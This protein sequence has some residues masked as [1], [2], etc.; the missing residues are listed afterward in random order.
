MKLQKP[1]IIFKNFFFFNEKETKVLIK[2]IFALILIFIVIN[3]GGIFYNELFFHNILK[4]ILLEL[5]FIIILLNPVNGIYLVLLAVPLEFTE[6]WFHY[7]VIKLYRIIIL[8]MF[9]SWGIRK[10]IYKDFKFLNYFKN[11]IIIFLI[12]FIFWNIVT[13]FYS[14]LWKAGFGEIIRMSF[15]LLFIIMLLDLIKKFKEIK[16]FIYYL[17]Y[18]SI[19]IALIGLY[20]KFTKTIIYYPKSPGRIGATFFDP[21][22]FGRYLM[23]NAIISLSLIL[24]QKK[25]FIKK[26]ILFFSLGL[27]FINIILTCS[28]SSLFGFLI[29]AIL[30]IVFHKQKKILIPVFFI[31]LI[32]IYLSLPANNK[33]RLKL[34]LNLNPD[35]IKSKSIIERIDLETG[36][37]KIIKKHYLFGV[38]VGSFPYY[39]FKY[40]EPT[41]KA[42]ESH[43]LLTRTLAELGIIGLLLSLYIIFIL[44]KEFYLLYKHSTNDKWLFISLLAATIGLFIHTILYSAFFYY[45]YLWFFIFILIRSKEQ[46]RLT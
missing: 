37:L 30:L 16:I 11:K 25:R 24:Y 1:G 26:I 35:K 8:F 18:I 46:L 27:F 31:L 22:M 20:E 9:L 19:I 15:Y 12:L 29:G 21:N 34:L 36:G 23:L 17:L 44:L 2:I 32:I 45:F 39:F 6:T 10:I 28:R 33:I 14:I 43:N 13:L 40:H 41:Y 7:H 42:S 5:L 38:G 4:I 3:T